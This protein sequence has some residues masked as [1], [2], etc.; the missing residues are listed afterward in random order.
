MV[1]ED[2]NGKSYGIYQYAE[3]YI[4]IVTSAEDEPIAGP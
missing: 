4:E 2:E 1:R 3:D